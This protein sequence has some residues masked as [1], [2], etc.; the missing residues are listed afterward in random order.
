MNKIDNSMSIGDFI[1][2]KNN[3]NEL[4]ALIG[5]KMDVYTLDEKNII[6]YDDKKVDST[7]I[8][9][10]IEEIQQDLEGKYYATQIG[11]IFTNHNDL[12][13]FSMKNSEMF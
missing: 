12:K 10:K 8:K 1:D 6:R 9:Q 4:Y 7:K 2:Y 11:I 13:Y 5:K 3:G